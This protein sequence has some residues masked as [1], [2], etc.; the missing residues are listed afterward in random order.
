MEEKK[1]SMSGGLNIWHIL[2]IIFVIA[3]IWGPLTWAWS[4]VFIPTYIWFGFVVMGALCS[5][6]KNNI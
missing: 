6:V 2:T 3:K 5:A 4:A 1:I